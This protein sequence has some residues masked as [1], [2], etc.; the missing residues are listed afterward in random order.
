[1]SNVTTGTTRSTGTFPSGAEIYAARFG[2]GLT[3]NEV[4]GKFNASARSSRFLA[5]C[6]AYVQADAELLEK[7]PEM[8]A[9]DGAAATD[10]EHDDYRAT[11]DL[12]RAERTRGVGIALLVAR[13]GLPTAKVKSIVG[14]EVGTKARIG[15]GARYGGRKPA[16]DAEVAEAAAEAAVAE[17][18][19]TVAEVVAD[20]VE[21]APA[22]AEKPAPRRRRKAATK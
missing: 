22:P 19:E 17:M 11:R 1:M 9:I 18:T 14:E 7:H 6:V 4:R 2:E 16:A 10:V 12:I 8:A 15:W 13:S 21:V 20:A 5:E 3:W